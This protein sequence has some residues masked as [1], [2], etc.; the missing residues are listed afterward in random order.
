MGPGEQNQDIELSGRR[1][2]L[3]NH[4]AEYRFQTL[5]IFPLVAQVSKCHRRIP[6]AFTSGL[7]CYKLVDRLV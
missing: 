7:M 1:L 2:Y 6:L 4:L 3:L 5:N